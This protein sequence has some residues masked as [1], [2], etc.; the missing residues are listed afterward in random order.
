MMKRAL[1]TATAAICIATSAAAADDIVELIKGRFAAGSGTYAH[2][3]VAVINHSATMLQ[4][5]EVECGFLRG[6]DLIATGSGVIENVRPGQ[7]A[8]KEVLGRDGQGADRAD[9][10]I[11]KYDTE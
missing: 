5:I 11:A 9:C 2:Q 1:L 8:Y 7:T 3:A 6:N 10:R 4:Y